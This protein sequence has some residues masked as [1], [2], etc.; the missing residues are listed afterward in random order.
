MLAGAKT[1]C[2]KE[3]LPLEI[4]IQ[5]V[6]K[7][8]GNRVCP[9]L[10]IPYDFTSRKTTNASANLVRLIPELGY[11]HGNCYVISRMA[12][13]IKLNV[14]KTKATPEQLRLVSDWIAQRNL[15]QESLVSA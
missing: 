14:I 9:V 11:V 15:N 8:I 4:N 6:I 5:D 12:N 7:L 3:G 2:R 1:V 13:N 10:G